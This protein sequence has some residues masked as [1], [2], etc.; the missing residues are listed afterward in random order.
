MNQ[1]FDKDTARGIAPTRPL[2][3]A[4]VVEKGAKWTFFDV[5]GEGVVEWLI[6]DFLEEDMVRLSKL[7]GKD[8][9]YSADYPLANLQARRWR[10][11]DPDNTK[12]DV[13]WP[14][15]DC[16][17]DNPIRVG[18]YVCEECRGSLDSE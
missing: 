4:Y 1:N 7:S 8:I 16:D 17:Q 9:G 3:I 11:L 12:R 14:C 15:P 2:N 5:E 10:P 6:E 13:L 18:D